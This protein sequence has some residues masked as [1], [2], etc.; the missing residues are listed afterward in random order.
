MPLTTAWSILCYQ[1]HQRNHSTSFWHN[2]NGVWKNVWNQSTKRYFHAWNPLPYT[3]SWL[4][5]YFSF[6]GDLD[7]TFLSEMLSWNKS[8]SGNCIIHFLSIVTVTWGG[9]TCIT[10]IYFHLTHWGRDKWTP[11]G[12]RY[13]Q[14]HFLEWKCLNSYKNFTEVCS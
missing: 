12:R 4:E 6:P 2:K 8:Q 11:F 10:V 5:Q 1:K 7:Q 14:V 3:H 13:F 9:R